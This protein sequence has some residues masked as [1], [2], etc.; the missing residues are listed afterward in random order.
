M[1]YDIL[2]IPNQNLVQ[3]Y[4]IIFLKWFCSYVATGSAGQNTQFEKNNL[5]IRKNECF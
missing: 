3:A 2:L 1:F 4:A 5:Q